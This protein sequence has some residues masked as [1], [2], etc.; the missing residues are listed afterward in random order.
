MMQILRPQAPWWLQFRLC[1]AFCRIRVTQGR[2]L[3]P[4]AGLTG[5]R[6]ARNAALRCHRT[7]R[8]RLKLTVTINCGTENICSKFTKESLKIYWWTN[9]GVCEEWSVSGQVKLC[10][11]LYL[12]STRTLTAL[13][14]IQAKKKKISPVSVKSCTPPSGCVCQI[15]YLSVLECK[16]KNGMQGAGNH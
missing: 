1:R 4:I 15:S 8:L 13:W 10:N 7:V 6:R 9:V 5:I 2:K 12:A 11:K 3:L 16:T 14:I